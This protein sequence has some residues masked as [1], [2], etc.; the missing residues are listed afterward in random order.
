MASSDDILQK[1]TN[2]PDDE[3]NES[4]E[5]EKQTLDTE[6][7][8]HVEQDS[9][10]QSVALTQEELVET[11]NP[12][13]NDNESFYQ[14]L[15][16]AMKNQPSEEKVGDDDQE[17]DEL[18]ELTKIVDSA[19][20]WDNL[21]FIPFPSRDKDSPENDPDH[22]SM[23]EFIQ[24][25]EMQFYSLKLK[26]QNDGLSSAFLKFKMTEIVNDIIDEAED[27]LDAIEENND[28]DEMEEE[29]K[30]EDDE[31][32]PVVDKY[33]QLVRSRQC[34]LRLIHFNQ[35]LDEISETESIKPSVLLTST[36]SPFS[37]HVRSEV[38]FIGTIHE[39]ITFLN[40]ECMS[41]LADES[42]SIQQRS[43][44]FKTLFR[45][46]T[47]FFEVLDNLTTHSVASKSL[48]TFVVSLIDKLKLNPTALSILFMT[49]LPLFVTP[50]EDSTF[51]R[52]PL[53]V[54]LP[55][56]LPIIEV[57][58]KTIADLFIEHKK[59][60]QASL[61]KASVELPSDAPFASN[62]LQRA[63]QRSMKPKDPSNNDAKSGSSASIALQY[64]LSFSFELLRSFRTHSAIHGYGCCCDECQSSP[65]DHSIPPPLPPLIE[66]TGTKLVS[67]L[68]ALL[69]TSTELFSQ[70]IPVPVA[71]PTNNLLNETKSSYAPII[72]SLPTLQLIASQ[73]TYLAAKLETLRGDLVTPAQQQGR[74]L[75]HLSC[76]IVLELLGIGF[77]VNYKLEH[78][79]NTPCTD[80]PF[81]ATIGAMI[82]SSLIP[83]VTVFAEL[84]AL[85]LTTT[86]CSD[87]DLDDEKIESI[88]SFVQTHL[89]SIQQ[90]SFFIRILVVFVNSLYSH[91]LFAAHTIK[92]DAINFN[93]DPTSYDRSEMVSSLL[94]K[95]SESITSLCNIPLPEESHTIPVTAPR[96]G[97]AGSGVGETV[98][99]LLCLVIHTLT[100][101]FK[102]VHRMD[103]YEKQNMKNH[104]STMPVSHFWMEG[105]WPIEKPQPA[106]WI[107]VNSFRAF[108]PL[109]PFHNDSASVT[110]EDVQIEDGIAHTIDKQTTSSSQQ[111]R[112]STVEIRRLSMTSPP[113]LKQ[114]LSPARRNGLGSS[115]DYPNINFQ[116]SEDSTL[117]ECLSIL[118]TNVTI[119]TTEALLQ[120]EAVFPGHE[121]L[122]E[123]SILSLSSRHES[124]SS[125]LLQLGFF[126]A[127]QTSRHCASTS[128]FILASVLIMPTQYTLMKTFF[129]KR[130][131]SCLGDCIRPQ[132]SGIDT[133]TFPQY[134]NKTPFSESVLNN[135]L[136][137]ICVQTTPQSL[138]L[139]PNVSF[140]LSSQDTDLHLTLRG[141]LVSLTTST[142]DDVRMETAISLQVFFSHLPFSLIES[143]LTASDIHK[144]AHLAKRG[145]TPLQRA[146]LRILRTIARIGVESS[147]QM[148]FPNVFFEQFHVS[149][150]ISYWIRELEKNRIYPKAALIIS[151]IL[152]LVHKDHEEQSNWKITARTTIINHL[153][154][155]IQS[156][157][158]EE[159]AQ[160]PKEKQEDDDI[161][162]SLVALHAI[163]EISEITNIDINDLTGL[164]LSYI[165]HPNHLVRIQAFDALLVL[166]SEQDELHLILQLVLA[167]P[168]STPQG[169]ESSINFPSDSDF[170]FQR[171]Q[172]SFVLSFLDHL[173]DLLNTSP[174]LGACFH[175]SIEFIA[176]QLS[177]I[178]FSTDT[179]KQIASI[180]QICDQFKNPDLT[181]SFEIKL[182]QSL[183]AFYATQFI[184]SLASMPSSEVAISSYSTLSF[185]RPS[186]SVD[187]IFAPVPELNKD[188]QIQLF[189][190]AESTLRHDVLSMSACL[191]IVYHLE[192]TIFLQSNTSEYEWSH[193]RFSIACQGAEWICRESIVNQIETSNYQRDIFFDDLTDCW[194]TPPLSQSQ[195]HD[196][197][198]ATRSNRNVS[199]SPPA[200]IESLFA[201]AVN[202]PFF[203]HSF[204]TVSP[205]TPPPRMHLSRS[206]SS[207]PALLVDTGVSDDHHSADFRSKSS[208]PEL[209]NLK[210][211]PSLPDS[212]LSV[213][214][215]VLVNPPRIPSSTAQLNGSSEQLKEHFLSSGLLHTNIE[216]CLCHSS[217][218][219]LFLSGGKSLERALTDYPLL[220]LRSL[221]TH[222]RQVCQHPFLQLPVNRKLLILAMRT[223]SSII[224]LILTQYSL[225]SYESPSD[226]PVQS[227]ADRTSLFHYFRNQQFSSVSH[228]LITS[229]HTS[230]QTVP[231]SL[232]NIMIELFV[233]SQRNMIDFLNLYNFK[234]EAGYL[235]LEWKQHLSRHPDLV[236]YI[237]NN[238]GVCDLP[239]TIRN[240]LETAL[241]YF[242]LSKQMNEV[243]AIE[244]QL[245]LAT[246]KVQSYKDL[247]EQYELNQ[248]VTESENV[249]TAPVSS[250]YLVVLSNSSVSQTLQ[251]V[252]HFSEPANNQPVSPSYWNSFPHSSATSPVPSSSRSV[253]PQ[254]F[255]HS[256][257]PILSHLSI[258]IPRTP[259]PASNPIAN[260]FFSVVELL[261]RLIPSLRPCDP[262]QCIQ[263]LFSEPEPQIDAC[264]SLL[265]GDD[266]RCLVVPIIPLSLDQKRLLYKPSRDTN[267]SIS[268]TLEAMKDDK[269][270]LFLSSIP[271]MS[272]MSHRFPQSDSEIYHLGMSSFPSQAPETPQASHVSHFRFLTKGECEEFMETI[273]AKRNIEKLSGS[274]TA[275]LTE[276]LAI[277]LATP[278]QGYLQMPKPESSLGTYAKRRTTA[279]PHQISLLRNLSLAPNQGSVFSNPFQPSPMI[280]KQISDS[281]VADLRAEHR[282]SV[283]GDASSLTDVGEVNEVDLT[284][285]L[286]GLLYNG[287]HLN[288][289][290]SRRLTY[291][292]P[293]SPQPHS[294]NRTSIKSS[295]NIPIE[296]AFAEEPTKE[297]TDKTT[298]FEAPAKLGP[299]SETHAVFKLVRQ[300]TS[301]KPDPGARLASQVSLAVSMV[302]TD[303]STAV[304]TSADSPKSYGSQFDFFSQ[305]KPQEPERRKTQHVRKATLMRSNSTLSQTF[306]N[307]H[308]QTLTRMPKVLSIYGEQMM[309][310][311]TPIQPESSSPKVETGSQNE[312]ET[313]PSD[314]QYISNVGLLCAIEKEELVNF[315]N[316]TMGAPAHVSLLDDS[317]A[318]SDYFD[319]LIVTTQSYL[320]SSSF[321]VL[322][323][324]FIIP[325][326]NSL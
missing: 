179:Q 149:H 154:A 195:T 112:A 60:S 106:P 292:G 102:L 218:L 230:G 31:D 219:H 114:V 4:F 27:E 206:E 75:I 245:S 142:E 317:V 17:V 94:A 257:S 155:C 123:R 181:R 320:P 238:Q 190:Q 90:H 1:S 24:S 9:P 256:Q 127:G 173:R 28:A 111:Q 263:M 318:A 194:Y 144:I 136:S 143:I 101:S 113:L 108:N 212:V 19:Y 214:P 303:M 45:P 267:P 304:S 183:H 205:P 242:K 232:L 269:Q 271:T 240:A 138:P 265:A 174:E 199:F 76:S 237:V 236:S 249:Q 311:D 18:I 202:V 315:F 145:K 252:V 97:L 307:F 170:S 130:D 152:C 309:G 217:P 42:H 3:P 69:S 34:Q 297:P 121:T 54:I 228:R 298:D 233:F 246:K 209:V 80:A 164:L 310:A 162:H 87:N 223:S 119:K 140:H 52:L 176:K 215:R 147:P 251:I 323:S 283:S 291:P 104:E 299:R 134:S 47:S 305:Q 128:S 197:H 129:A 44:H 26:E 260:S 293:E 286:D 84:S 12:E 166:S 6:G 63:T 70:L 171:A 207:I 227:V 5:E 213:T 234:A 290:R 53:C 21:P 86:V 16:E 175:E 78:P 169:T 66:T 55:A 196:I 235:T 81:G 188:D 296:E 198:F 272:S 189:E 201:D 159:Q 118:L 295:P 71:L 306:M 148:G 204:A 20:C 13:I 191:S 253:P 91:S 259:D 312:S 186:D 229:I 163:G 278:K 132:K 289:P 56:I 96:G 32:K 288:S 65:E 67:V 274:D 88:E 277:A 244:N 275:S 33:Q 264:M 105:S 59:Q 300:R 222:L 2:E 184:V 321:V 254:S 39:C 124:P 211:S 51:V 158:R 280:P 103:K 98:S 180:N 23:P 95:E 319:S 110:T 11:D 165:I 243:V 37:V 156:I 49:I 216:T 302:S 285:N 221:I 109:E 36:P 131:S 62:P 177:I 22:F 58:S 157:Y 25:S 30:E 135:F 266:V 287:S 192:F 224:A 322:V 74:T 146:C 10:S 284:S 8:S 324:K 46:V 282:P 262:N 279:F 258:N 83:I 126:L 301:V 161:V 255:Q 40:T 308:K 268:N 150:A 68:P 120:N 29:E 225:S 117:A 99:S 7:S 270:L 182:K 50:D 248:T 172:M 316:Q 133:I 89:S 73:T 193:D 72:E 153:H 139:C 168:M 15:A 261:E 107:P 314:S 167:I 82:S 187:L 185:T 57:L 210:R 116:K 247:M 79:I 220:T 151:H 93:V 115:H 276:Q 48:S 226:I 281:D 239:P 125:L 326:H 313:S 178:C 43:L 231:S 92:T 100:Y 64:L 61:P 85:S 141:L 250:Y 241:R 160:T 325:C 35:I 122:T 200:V 208:T 38:D 14:N 273:R 203:N 41:V 294:D 137:N 77:I